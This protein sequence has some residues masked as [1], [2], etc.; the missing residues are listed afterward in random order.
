M[1]CAPRLCASA[2]PMPELVTPTPRSPVAGVH[3]ELL[4]ADAG[5]GDQRTAIK[6]ASPSPTI[7]R[8]GGADVAPPVTSK[9]HHKERVDAHLLV[10]G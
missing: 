4:P 10:L 9:L 6:H 8:D 7:S 1:S 5:D 3:Y 2:V